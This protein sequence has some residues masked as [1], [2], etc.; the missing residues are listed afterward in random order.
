V[1]WTLKQLLEKEFHAQ[2]LR[3]PEGRNLNDVAAIARPQKLANVRRY[4]LKE[5]SSYCQIYNVINIYVD[6]YF[7][8]YNVKIYN[9]MYIQYI[10]F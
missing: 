3:E 6:I 9:V 5:T 8:V 4:F 7:Y 1:P 2:H 10:T